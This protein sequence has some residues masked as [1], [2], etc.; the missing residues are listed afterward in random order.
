[1]LGINI[2]KETMKIF[3]NN[4]L[5]LFATTIFLVGCSKEDLTVLNPSASTTVSLSVDEVTLNKDNAGQTALTI[6]WDDPN[7]GFS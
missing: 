1:M 4:V 6:S 3:L 5:I 2:K 7:Y